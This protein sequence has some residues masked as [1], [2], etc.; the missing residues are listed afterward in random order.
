MPYQG[1]LKENEFGRVRVHV[2]ETSNPS[3]KKVAKISGQKGGKRWYIVLDPAVAPVGIYGGWGRF[4]LTVATV[5]RK[6]ATEGCRLRGRLPP[7]KLCGLH[8]KLRGEERERATT[9]TP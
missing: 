8:C 3:E 1:W 9:R 2:D 5:I 7:G 4:Q 6:D